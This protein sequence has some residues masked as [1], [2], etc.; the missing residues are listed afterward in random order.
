MDSDH[1]LV[2][3]LALILVGA[4]VAIALT[5]PSLFGGES[6]GV[7]AANLGSFE[8][9]GPFC[10]DPNTTSASAATRDAPAGEA[11]VLTGTVPVPSNDTAVSASLNEFGPQRFI[12]EVTRE[13]PTDTPTPTPTS[14]PTPTPT[15]TTTPTSTTTDGGTTGTA[16][17]GTS[18]TERPANASRVNGTATARE[19]PTDTPTP[20]PTP[21]DTGSDCHPTIRYNATIHVSQPSEYTVFVTYEGELVG[22]H[23]GEGDDTGWYD[24]IPEQPETE[25]PANATATNASSLRRPDR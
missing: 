3:F 2:L 14:T 11:L 12:L 13:T 19:T 22:A 4:A 25:E 21:A 9:T 18:G 17:N 10:G 6:E 15:P 20:T 16:A 1:V 8:T 7:A 24:R 23:W 5:S